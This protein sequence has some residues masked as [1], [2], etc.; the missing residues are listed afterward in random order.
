M[1]D[2]LEGWYEEI[3]KRHYIKLE[4]LVVVNGTIKSPQYK[5]TAVISAQKS[6][7]AEL[8]ANAM[9]VVDL[10]LHIRLVNHGPPR[11]E[12][13]QLLFDDGKRPDSVKALSIFLRYYKMKQRLFWKK[14]EANAGP[15]VLPPGEDP[16]E[17]PPVPADN[18][19]LVDERD[20]E[21]EGARVSVALACNHQ[22]RF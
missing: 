17:R 2:N 5:V 16:S 19:I 18:T 1:K 10:G 7:M 8:N 4:D 22:T 3:K 12:Q 15:H 14:I 20:S 13:R 6:R 21:D 9:N 11:S